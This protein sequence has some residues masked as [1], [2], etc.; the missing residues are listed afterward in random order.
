MF[1]RA[2]RWKPLE[3][4]LAVLG[5]ESDAVFDITQEEAEEGRPKPLDTD[6]LLIRLIPSLL[7][8]HGMYLPQYFLW[9]FSLSHLLDCPFLQG[10]AFIFA[11]NFSAF[12]SS[13]LAGQYLNAAVEVLESA[14]AGVPVKISAVKAVQK[15]VHL[16]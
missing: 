12:L 7:T 8:V 9:L 6:S 2:C 5:A 14:H 15:L 13:E 3:A 4:V 1:T 10:R 11:G 16:S